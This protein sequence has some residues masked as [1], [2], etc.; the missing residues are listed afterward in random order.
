[1]M[2]VFYKM[3]VV[4]NINFSTIGPFN[5]KPISLNCWDQSLPP[6]SYEQ[7]DIADYSVKGL[8][9]YSCN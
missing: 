1:M 5:I 9:I 3:G 2:C 8:C 4:Y 7:I 6:A